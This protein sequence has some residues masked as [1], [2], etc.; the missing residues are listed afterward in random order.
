[1][2][3]L[4]KMITEIYPQKEMM[5]EAC[6]RNGMKIKFLSKFSISKINKIIGRIESM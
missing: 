3:L 2:D 1:M 6:R 5:K 4:I